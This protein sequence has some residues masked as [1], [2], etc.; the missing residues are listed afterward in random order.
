MIRAI[1]LTFSFFDALAGTMLFRTISFVE[2]IKVLHMHTSHVNDTYS[3][4]L[5]AFWWKLP[6]DPCDPKWTRMNV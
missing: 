4:G 2:G 3:V 1:P 5:D 6:V